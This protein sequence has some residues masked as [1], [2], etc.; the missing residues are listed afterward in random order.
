[1]AYLEDSARVAALRQANLLDAQPEPDF[2][3]LARLVQRVLGTDVALLS[4][5]DAD[6]QLALGHGGSAEPWASQREL[7]VAASICR[8]VVSSGGPGVIGDTRED[9]LVAG[10]DAV[11]ELGVSAYAGF[12]VHGPQGDTLGALCAMDLGP[13][14][15]D[16]D[17][18]EILAELAG[19]ATAL[20]VA[21][22]GARRAAELAERYLLVTHAAREIGAARGDAGIFRRIATLAVESIADACVVELL[23]DGALRTAAVACRDRPATATEHRR[24]EAMLALRAGATRVADGDGAPELVLPLIFRGAPLGTVWLGRTPD[25]PP[26]TAEEVELLETLAGHVSALVS[27]ERLL[28]EHRNV[29]ELLQRTLLPSTLPTI[30]GLRVATWYE[31][32]DPEL[33]VGGDFYDVI[34]RPDGSCLLVIG[35]VC[36]RGPGAAAMTGVVRHTLRGLAAHG[37][38]IADTIAALN[39]SVF[40]ETDGSEFVT[41]AVV[42]LD[43]DRDGPTAH[44]TLAGHPPPLLVGRDGAVSSLGTPGLPLGIAPDASYAVVD[45]PLTDGDSLLLYTDGL[46]ESHG[47]QTRFDDAALARLLADCGGLAA[48]DLLTRVQIGLATVEGPSVSDDVAVMAARVAG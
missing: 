26:F 8:H 29:S 30:P 48:E 36:G 19:T 15:W 40:R 7:P 43:G 31:A 1:M 27:A 39:R 5:V 44:A 3:R 10:S 16:S 14:R 22:D 34:R 18:L 6:R 4:L 21:R 11:V 28:E 41:L 25:A 47:A 45:A 20:I 46:V 33:E 38:D 17:E 35:D 23:H 32:G 42:E 13:R 2:D 37:G 12:P 24:H 9:P